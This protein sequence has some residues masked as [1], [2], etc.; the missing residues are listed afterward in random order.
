MNLAI[1]LLSVLNVPVSTVFILRH[2]DN[3]ESNSKSRFEAWWTCSIDA[4][5]FWN[6]NP[7][8]NCL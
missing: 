6:E 1:S 5:L 2:D 8:K 3:P 7:V 4:G